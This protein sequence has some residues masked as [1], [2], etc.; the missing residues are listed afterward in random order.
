M[1][2]LP[3]RRLLAVLAHPDDESFGPGGTLALYA[4]SGVDVHLICATSGEAGDVQPEFL[5]DYDQVRQLRLAELQCATAILGLADVHLL[6]YRDSGMPGSPD[7]L[8]P[9]ALAAAPTNEVADKIATLIRQ[10]RPQVILTFDP[11][12]GYHHPDHI[13]VHRATVEAFYAAGD[14]YRRSDRFP[15]YVPHK[16]YY[17]VMSHRFLRLL[18]FI[19]PIFGIDP[20][21]WGR[22]ADINLVEITSQSFPI[23][24]RIDIRPVAEIKREAAACHKSQSGPPTSKLFSLLTRFVAGHETFM[25]AHPTAPKGLFER[26]LFEGI[27][28]E[29]RG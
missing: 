9:E 29:A 2:R 1:N 22:N 8:H 21:R 7:N 23:H 4:R 10:I 27:K 12:G 16:L 24:A 28:E 26:D 3:N 17:H 19:L 15:P 14:P 5:Q 20:R 13:A 6:G 11:Q 18:I 25:R